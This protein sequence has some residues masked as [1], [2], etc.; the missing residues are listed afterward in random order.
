M[1]FV[2]I[3][4]YS[5]DISMPMKLRFANIAILPVVPLPTNGSKTVS[6]SLLHVLMWSSANC[7]GNGAGCSVLS[8]KLVT[9]FHIFV[10]G[11]KSGTSLF[12]FPLK[13]FH[14]PHKL[15]L[16][17]IKLCVFGLPLLKTNIYSKIC[18]YLFDFAFAGYVLLFFSKIMVSCSLNPA[19]MKVNA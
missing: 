8:L 17:Q 19:S 13:S 7:S 4:Q 12:N 15:C 10:L 14:P 9:Y 1:R 16:S 3:S 6:P 2:A 5:F 11:E 18:V